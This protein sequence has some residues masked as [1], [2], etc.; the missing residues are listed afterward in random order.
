LCELPSL[1]ALPELKILSEQIASEKNIPG[2]GA[3]LKRHHGHRL[4]NLRNDNR[5]REAEYEGN[6]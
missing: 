4:A 5:E 3:F 2:K 6:F 1:Q